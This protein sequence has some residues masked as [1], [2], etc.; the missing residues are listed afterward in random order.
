MILLRRKDAFVAE[1]C[2]LLFM[3]NT[4]LSPHFPNV[5]IACCVFLCMCRR[6]LTL[7]LHN[8]DC[9]AGRVWQHGG[10]CLMN[11]QGEVARAAG[12]GALGHWCGIVLC[13][14]VMYA[15]RSI[16]TWNSLNTRVS[17]SFRLQFIFSCAFGHSN[18]KFYLASDGG[19]LGTST[20][21]LC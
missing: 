4:S 1:K 21:L 20:L 16:L 15:C 5:M 9:T 12:D 11:E 3:E 17:F 13:V 18:S 14:L 19:A 7:A 2:K 10:V 6:L 8:P